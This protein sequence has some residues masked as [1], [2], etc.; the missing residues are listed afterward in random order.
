MRYYK[1]PMRMALIALLGLLGGGYELTVFFGT[2]TICETVRRT[3][4]LWQRYQTET[5]QRERK[6]KHATS[7]RI[8]V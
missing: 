5:T 4:I 8:S 6:E 1:L 3:K 2:L 7:H